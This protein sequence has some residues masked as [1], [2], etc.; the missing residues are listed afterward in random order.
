MPGAAYFASMGALRAGAG[1]VRLFYEQKIASSFSSAPWEVVRESITSWRDILKETE[2]AG[3]LLLGPG[4]GRQHKERWCQKLIRHSPIPLILDA[5]ALSILPNISDMPRDTILTPHRGEIKLLIGEYSSEKMLIKLAQTYVEQTNSILLCKGS[6]TILFQRERD[7][8]ILKIGNP[9]MATAGSGDI[10]AGI[11][12]T[13]RAQK[14]AGYDAACV[15]ACLHG[16]A[17]D[18]AAEKWGERGVIASDILEAIPKAYMQ[19]LM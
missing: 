12:A 4:L 15:G 8:L 10:L 17:G 16:A 11:I 9:G 14:M 7:P 13:L 2:R 6:P 1:I 5:D 3:S 18:L 19:A